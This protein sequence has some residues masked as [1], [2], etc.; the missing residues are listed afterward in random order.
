MT[1]REK[2]IYLL[3]ER[4]Y[5]FN[6]LFKASGFSS[7]STLNKHLN[8]LQDDGVIEKVIENR[9]PVY[10]IKMDAG[11]IMSEILGVFFDAILSILEAHVPGMELF[12]RSIILASLKLR[13]EQ[14]M[15]KIM[16]KPPLTKDENH[17]LLL[18]YI[19]ESLAELDPSMDK[20]R[21]FEFIEVFEL[22]GPEKDFEVYVEN[23][24]RR[25]R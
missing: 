9:Q 12:F 5:R 1:N 20:S 4:S 15:K 18:K 2:I 11:V 17:Q 21:R 24:F 22:A 8:E 7:K 14:R 23:R 10:R 16:K 13:I 25:K 19:D 6:D 3:H